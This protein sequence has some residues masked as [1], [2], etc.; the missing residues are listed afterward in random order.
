M[1]QLMLINPRE[2][3]TA[4]KAAPKRRVRR[5][6]SPVAANPRKRRVRRNPIAA[7]QMRKVRRYRRNPVGGGIMPQITGAL[8]GGAGA[9]AV[10]VVTGYLPLPATM[11]TGMMRHVTMGGLGLALGMFAKP[12][13]GRAAAQM[14][15]GAMTVAAYGLLKDMTAGMLPG[16]VSV[17]PASVVAGLGYANPTP[18]LG[19]YITGSGSRGMGEFVTGAGA[20]QSGFAYQ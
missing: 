19:E 9:V 4:K 20:A 13:L 10:D 1:G 2:R 16:S 14:G 17:V 3:R 18:V 11:R 12:L 8:M 5:N 7:R 6:P 15:T